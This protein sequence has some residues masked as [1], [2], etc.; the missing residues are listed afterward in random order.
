MRANALCLALVLLAGAPS[1]AGPPLYAPCWRNVDNDPALIRA[2]FRLVDRLAVREL[3]DARASFFLEE[4]G[5]VP[6]DDFVLH[7]NYHE[8]REDAAP[9]RVTGIRRLQFD[10]RRLQDVS[11]VVGTRRSAWVDRRPYRPGRYEPLNQTWLVRLNDCRVDDVREARDLHY[12]L[13]D[14]PD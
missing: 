1:H 3:Y 9:L 10:G 13:E 7:I 8:G 14:A 2:L 4:R 6:I 12:L 5:F 11:Y